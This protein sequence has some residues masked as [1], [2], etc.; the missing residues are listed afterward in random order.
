MRRLAFGA[1]VAAV[2]SVAAPSRASL[3]PS[4]AEQVRHGVKTAT[5]LPRVRALVA[6]P[7]LSADEAAA[8]LIAPMSATPF[9]PAHVTFLDDLV[10]NG[11]PTASQPVLVVAAV[12]GVLARA[13]AILGQHALDLDRAPAALA[14]LARVYGWI[15]RVATA[16]RAANVPDSARTQ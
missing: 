7:D 5:D 3:T 10:F 14:E 1:V 2:V 6:R 4:E 12:R 11:A 16:S 15:E 13:D 8:A 9:D